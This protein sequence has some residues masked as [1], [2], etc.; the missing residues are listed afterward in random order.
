MADEAYLSY[1]QV[2]QELQINRSE[3]NRLIRDGRLKD[4]VISGETKFRR[5]EVA[6]LK[7]ALQ[8]RPTVMA[9]EGGTEPTTD[10]LLAGAAK[11]T[12]PETEV[13]EG[14]PVSEGT[15]ILVT[16]A[17]AVERDTEVLEEEPELELEMPGEGKA[18]LDKPLAEAT[19]LSES[20]LDTDL[21]L[22]AMKAKPE[23]AEEEDFFDFTDTLKEDEFELEGKETA[24]KEAPAAKAPAAKAPAAKAPAAAGAPPKADEVVGD[25]LGLE[26]EA[27]GGQV[28]EE[29]LLSEIM[30]I[31][32]A[33][34]P[35]EET[36]D[37]TAD[38]T[39]MEEP[40]YEATELED[41]LAGGKEEEGFG[42]EFAVPIP[43]HVGAEA[44]AS[45]GMVALLVISLV[46]LIVAGLFVVDNGGTPGF[47][48]GAT[49]WA[50][51]LGGS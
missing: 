21:E 40:T 32:G 46:I 17:G 8:K 18:Q 23:A 19:P 7:K 26:E 3:L 42:E 39:T 11:S 33:E 6:D 45:A 50:A 31:E 14:K 29:E 47:T 5:V 25:I 27:A 9:E 34:E 51:K 4:H 49:H 16:P 20:A 38:I 2:L 48:G 36:A 22:Q 12:E 15:D 10:V 1:E 35:E 13:L 43:E 37:I 24:K 44:Q 41:V 28:S 30:E